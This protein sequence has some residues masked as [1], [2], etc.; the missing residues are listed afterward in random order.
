MS[1]VSVAIFSVETALAASSNATD[2]L[3]GIQLSTP[4]YA[5]GTIGYVRT[6]LSYYRYDPSSVAAPDGINVVEPLGGPGR[7]IIIPLAPAATTWQV[8]VATAAALPPAGNVA[9]DARI[10]LDT[11]DIHAWDGAAWVLAGGAPPVTTWK[12][13]VATAAALPMVGNA[14]GDSRLTLDTI[15]IHAWDGVAWSVVGGGA[16]ATTWMDPVANYAALPAVGNAA[17]DARVTL[18]TMRIYL[19]TGIAWLLVTV[20]YWSEVGSEL[21]PD[22]PGMPV[23]VVVDA[24]AT[25]TT[26]GIT[27]RNTTPASAGAP[28]NSPCS[29]WSGQVW[30]SVALASH[31]VDWL[32]QATGRDGGPV[33]PEWTLHYRIDSGPVTRLVSV[34]TVGIVFE[35]SASDVWITKRPRSAAGNGLDVGIIGQAGN[36]GGNAGGASFL[37]AAPANSG[38][39]AG[40]A[41]MQDSSGA[42]QVS[43]DDTGTHLLGLAGPSDAVVMVSAAGTTARLDGLDG[44]ALMWRS[45]APV[46]DGVDAADVGYDDS[47]VTPSFGA[48]NVQAALDFVKSYVW[49][50]DLREFGDGSNG[51][52]VVSGATTLTDDV[53]YDDLTLNA[54]AALTV[55]C[56]CVCVRG[57]LSLASAPADAI[58][59]YASTRNGG[60]GATAGTGGTAG[61]VLTA[62]TYVVTGAGTAG[63]A[64][65]TAAG[66]QA[67]APSAA[68]VGLGGAGGQGSAGGLGSGGAGGALRA[69]AAITARRTYRYPEK[70]YIRQ[71]AGVGGGGGGAGG[72]GGGGDG[73][74]GAGGGGGGASGALTRI[75]ARTIDRG[76]GTAAGCISANGGTGG[77]GGSATA[78]NR[79]GG[80]GAGGGGGGAIHLSYRYITGTTATG[81]VTASGGAGGNGGAGFGTGVGGN[82]GN[83]GAGGQIRIFNMSTGT[84][85]GS[86]FTAGSSGTAASGTTGGTGGA[87]GVVQMD[88]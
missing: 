44:Q 67:T 48:T 16:P 33:T 28:Q 5:A 13:P 70:T 83:G 46:F 84:S 58:R 76:A 53:F 63:G 10:T 57:I 47:G 23:A 85:A 40:A 37:R 50:E 7:W 75:A 24:I 14:V 59:S 8:P 77:N 30:N 27:V 1:Q 61:A 49:G 15:L 4:Q 68:A 62:R 9:G 32:A 17:G 79:G 6:T 11:L 38:A 26:P 25:A 18:D 36:G 54:G 65:G 35:D 34:T 43:V 74:A 20:N 2:S 21:R 69:G 45:G 86:E 51:D 39:A 71:A 88:L 31:Q 78:G 41:E 64:G 29:W 3:D 22:T 12:D 55:G 82:G 42:A 56:V 73:T 19:W 66:T 52:L 80:G 72:G 60:A 81:A 87:G